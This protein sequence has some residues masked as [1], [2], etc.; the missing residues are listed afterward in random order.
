MAQ[1]FMVRFGTNPGL[2]SLANGAFQFL[3]KKAG[4]DDQEMD[5]IWYLFFVL[6]ASMHLEK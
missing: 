6:V 4:I 3:W 2:K 5:W 1:G